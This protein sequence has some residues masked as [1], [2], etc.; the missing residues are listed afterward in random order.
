MTLKNII[1][2]YVL[3]KFTN[4]YN[5]ILLYMED[6]LVFVV[7]N[8]NKQIVQMDF[9]ADECVNYTNVMSLKEYNELFK[10]QMMTQDN[11]NLDDD[12]DINEMDHN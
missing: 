6:T 5:I 10:K 9:I 3:M 7:L 12:D 1:L 8:E 4:Y 2:I 11:N